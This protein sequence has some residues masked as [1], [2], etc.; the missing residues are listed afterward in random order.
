MCLLL[1]LKLERPILK[2]SSLLF[3]TH[4][5]LGRAILYVLIHYPYILNLRAKI[6]ILI[7]NL[8]FLF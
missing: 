7:P 5:K 6:K 8:T 1:Y 2:E 3:G 4:Q